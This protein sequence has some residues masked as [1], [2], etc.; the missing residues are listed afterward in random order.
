MSGPIF[1]DSSFLQ[2]GFGKSLQIFSLDIVRKYDSSIHSHDSPLRYR[3]LN[4]A[5]ADG[6]QMLHPLDDRVEPF[7]VRGITERRFLFIRET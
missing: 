3:L 5:S 4:A 1:G 7:K 6:R 2:D